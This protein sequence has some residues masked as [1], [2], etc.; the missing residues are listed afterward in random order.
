MGRV[1][2]SVTLSE[3]FG[4]CY[5][6][7][8][9]LDNCNSKAQTSFLSTKTLNDDSEVPYWLQEMLHSTIWPV[10]TRSSAEALK[11]M[12]FDLSSVRQD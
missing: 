7:N 12:G 3:R 9:F 2:A 6:L 10:H 5:R 1:A 11:R 8:L 4:I